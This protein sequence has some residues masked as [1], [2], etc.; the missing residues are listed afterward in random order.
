[1]YCLCY[2]YGICQDI[3][4]IHK[5]RG[6]INKYILLGE[7]LFS[8]FIYS[9]GEVWLEFHGC[10]EDVKDCVKVLG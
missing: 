1:M 5:M 6:V 10:G 9:N 8:I 3:G 7:W 4:D 2:P